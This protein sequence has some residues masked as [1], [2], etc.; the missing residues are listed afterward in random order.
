M[1]LTEIFFD[2]DTIKLKRIVDHTGELGY[3]EPGF[4]C[5]KVNRVYG[6][7]KFTP[8]PEGRPL[9]YASYVMSIDGKIAFEDDEVGPLIAKNNYLDPDGAFADFWVLNMLRAYCD[10]I[11]IGSGTMIKEPEYSGSAYDPDLLAAR[12]AAGKPAAPWTVIVTRSGR[13][14]PYGNQVFSCREIPFL[15]ATSP[16][17]YKNLLKEIPREHIL[18][19][20]ADSTGGRE[21]ISRLIRENPGKIMVTVS[22]ED[23]SMEAE[24]LMKVL[25]AMGME[26]V[27]VESPA[28]C[29][30]LMG[31]GLLDEI[32]INTS[33]VFVGGQATGIG[34]S[35]SSFSSLEHPHCQ[36]VS[37]HLHK[38]S[39]IYTRYR[40]GYGVRP[41]AK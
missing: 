1:A 22:G 6:D 10:G 15:V 16:E 13:D 33:C 34:T 7:L 18:L 19:P 2:A 8:K 36:V 30:H 24:A 26:K 39:F 9:T 14:I 23:S 38:A 12:K 28:Y 41:A 3:T 20:A 17:G 35:A 11:I 37:M 29:H 27:L 21:E 40:F 32:F 25:E 31:Q 4:P 5:E